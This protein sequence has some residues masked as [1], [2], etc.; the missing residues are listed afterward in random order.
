MTKIVLH[1]RYTDSKGEVFTITGLRPSKARALVKSESKPNEAALSMSIAFLE[2][3][4]TR[5]KNPRK[6]RS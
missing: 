6:P 1:G 2:S 5:V 4:L 3:A